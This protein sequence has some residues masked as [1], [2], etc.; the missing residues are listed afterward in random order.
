MTTQIGDE[1]MIMSQKL[2][3]L[4][5]EGEVRGVS[6]DPGGVVYVVRW[7]DTGYESLLRPGPD[8]VIK[9]RH[10]HGSGGAGPRLSRLRHPLEWRHSRDLERRQQARDEHLARRVQDI[11]AGLGLTQMD[12]SIGGGRVVHIPKVVS[13]AAGPP[14]GLDIKILPGQS[15][16]DF[17][18]HERTIAYDLG[19]A[20]VR[21]VPLGPDRIRLELLP[22]DPQPGHPPTSR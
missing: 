20:E 14:V 8:V 3:Q 22:H 21:V 1:I 12:F 13:M 7:S 15:P 16:E 18:A 11:I 10:G 5:R 9:H 2:H 17:S 4:V 19:V 6:D